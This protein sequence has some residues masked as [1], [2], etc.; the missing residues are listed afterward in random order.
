LT[1]IPL[2]GIKK[3]TEIHHLKH[4]DRR[5]WMDKK[6]FSQIRYGLGKTQNQL[7]QLLGTSPK[8]IQSFEQGWRKIPVHTERQLLFLLTLKRSKGEGRRPCWVMRNCPT[9]IRQN[10]PA[11][12]FQTGNL[13]WFINGTICQGEVQESWQKKMKICRRCEVF[14]L[15]LLPL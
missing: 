4:R 11:W 3:F 12:E 1:D 5:T 8:A 10:C 14:R 2:C 15:V 13:C 7:A 6:E 9:K